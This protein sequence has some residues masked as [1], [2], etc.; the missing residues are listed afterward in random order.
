MDT[1]HNEAATREP[2]PGPGAG[3]G[4]DRWTSEHP[5]GTHG[6]QPSRHRA[7]SDCVTEGRSAVSGRT[8][9]GPRGTHSQPR[10]VHLGSGR[11]T[12]GRPL[13]GGCHM[14]GSA[15]IHP[16]SPTRGLLVGSDGTP[17]TTEGEGC[18]V[19]GWAGLGAPAG[20]GTGEASLHPT[21]PIP[22]QPALAFSPQG[23]CPAVRMLTSLHTVPSVLKPACHDPRSGG[24]EGRDRPSGP[25]QDMACGR[26]PPEEPLAR[27][28]LQIC[29]KHR[30]PQRLAAEAPTALN[31]HLGVGNAPRAPVTPSA[32]GW[33]DGVSNPLVHEKN[34]VSC[35]G[36]TAP[37]PCS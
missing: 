18:A 32:I 31:P 15:A 3:E 22:V 29:L 19:L 24:C 4:P 16:A 21:G 30:Q 9:E 7:C 23:T 28:G 25:R 26:R 10:P 12:V 17:Q 6:G 20:P 14:L 37:T 35:E 11:Q 33:S 1:G 2:L 36:S 34:E 8:E 5:S 27:S 13:A